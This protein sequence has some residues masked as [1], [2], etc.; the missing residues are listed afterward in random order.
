MVKRQL[1]QQE[2]D[3]L[4]KS[5]DKGA[6]APSAPS[7]VAFDFRHLD[8]IAKSQL[9]ALHFLHEHFIRNLTSSLSVYLRSYVSGNLISVE[10]LQYADFADSLSTPTCM[11]NLSMQPYEGYCVVEINQTLVGPLLDLILGG[12]GKSITQLNREI[13]DVEE[14]LFE[15][16]FRIIA[17]D[18]TEV[19]K[20]VVPINFA[21]D[22]L[23]TNP[24]LSNR[25]ARNETAVVIT[26]ELRI[27]EIN[28]MVNLAIPSIALKM[29]R[30]RFDVQWVIQKPG[31][32]DQEQI[33][34]RR[35]A[36][37]LMLKV[38]CELRG[39][40]MRFR[41]LVNLEV[42]N[43]IDLGIAFDGRTVI[44][45]NGAVKFTS[46]LAANGSRMV[47]TVDSL[48]LNGVAAAV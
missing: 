36:R 39:G 11:I 12:E 23:E 15:G 47:A 45:V 29:M 31:S 37:D 1:N 42:G 35:L 34:K 17:H 4:F 24:Q 40:T 20:P 10:Q 25:I 18:L 43:V 26:M 9:S 13:T 3:E 6:E 33:I 27:G 32:R 46:D 30:Q 8:R 19:W 38:D 2:I 21:V 14:D 44:T 22:T 5:N 41:D 48:R 16:L 28:G 7:T